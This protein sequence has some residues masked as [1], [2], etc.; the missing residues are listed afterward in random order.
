MK[1]F[2]TGFSKIKNVATLKTKPREWDENM[3]VEDIFDKKT[4]IQIYEQ[5][6]KLKE[7]NE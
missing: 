5:L 1:E 6:L 3:F 2:V 4:F 7:E